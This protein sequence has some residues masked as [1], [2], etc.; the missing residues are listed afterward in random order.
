MIPGLDISWEWIGEPQAFKANVRFA[1]GSQLGRG[2][3]HVEAQPAVYERQRQGSR[4][5]CYVCWTVSWKLKPGPPWQQSFRGLGWKVRCLK[6]SVTPCHP[7]STRRR[8]YTVQVSLLKIKKKSKLLLPEA[9]LVWIHIQ[10]MKMCLEINHPLGWT[11]SV[12]CSA[13]LS[14]NGNGRALSDGK[15]AGDC[16]EIRRRSRRD[17][18]PCPAHP[19]KPL[20][21]IGFYMIPLSL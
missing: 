6:L 9:I 18:T 20:L 21:T 19:F 7:N 15:W 16:W 2:K 8:I 11:V 3:C 10:I 4:F 17:A 12:P 13:L 5:I 1:V 14:A